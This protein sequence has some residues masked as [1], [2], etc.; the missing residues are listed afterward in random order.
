MRRKINGNY[1]KTGAVSMSESNDFNAIDPKQL[2]PTP[3][4]SYLGF[5]SG[6]FAIIKIVNGHLAIE[7]NFER[8]NFMHFVTDLNIKAKV[9]SWPAG[10]VSPVKI[11]EKFNFQWRKATWICSKQ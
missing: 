9:A 3:D 10:E 4:K 11:L 7:I 5:H 1:K 6:N 2:I 8:G